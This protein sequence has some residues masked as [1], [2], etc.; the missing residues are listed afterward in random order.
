MTTMQVLVNGVA[1]ERKIA[2][3]MHWNGYHNLAIP[4]LHNGESIDWVVG[5]RIPE[6]R[7]W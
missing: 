5:S 3:Y 1:G 6:I 4:T 7:S 2:Y